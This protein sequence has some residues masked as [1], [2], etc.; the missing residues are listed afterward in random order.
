[1]RRGGIVTLSRFYLRVQRNTARPNA[2]QPNKIRLDGSGMKGAND[3]TVVAPPWQA[4]PSPIRV[5]R[6]IRG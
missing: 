5:I 2:P 4:L 6:V 1:M 3:A